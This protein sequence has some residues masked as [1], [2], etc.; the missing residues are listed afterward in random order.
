M[1]ELMF[2]NIF[3]NAIKFSLPNN[4]IYI[5][6]TGDRIYQN[7]IQITINNFGWGIPENDLE[8]IFSSYLVIRSV[9]FIKRCLVDYALDYIRPASL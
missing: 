3:D 6:P 1:L 8:K 7:E 5:Y 4:K 9:R 2:S